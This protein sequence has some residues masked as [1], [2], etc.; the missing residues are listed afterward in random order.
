MRA[1]QL[2]DGRTGS[3]RDAG[4]GRRRGGRRRHPVGYWD[5]AELRPAEGDV[6]GPL[7]HHEHRRQDEGLGGTDVLAEAE[8]RNGSSAG[9]VESRSGARRRSQR[10]AVGADLRGLVGL[11]RRP[12]TELRLLEHRAI[13]KLALDV[14][15]RRRRTHIRSGHRCGPCRSGNGVRT[16]V[17]AD[18]H[19]GA[20]AL[21]PW[22][23]RRSRQ[24]TPR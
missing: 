18:I 2:L 3:R 13:R 15:P 11:A 22:T 12:R 1:A 6:H 7:L 9:H 8:G 16:R 10:L 19:T 23:G 17:R 24:R 21:G 20:G 4:H 14:L 5:V